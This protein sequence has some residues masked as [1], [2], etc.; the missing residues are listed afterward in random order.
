L[1][2]NVGFEFLPKN[3]I[4]FVY[5]MFDADK[6]GLPDYLSSQDYDDYKDSHLESM[7]ANYDGAT[8]DNRFAWKM[9]YFQS[10]NEDKDFDPVFSDPSGYDDGLITTSEDTQKGAQVQGS[11]NFTDTT[12]TSG[13]DWT[14]YDIDSDYSPQQSE[15]DNL[16]FFVLGK[17]K[18]INQKLI[19][20]GGLRYDDFTV[21][22]IEPA[23]N[24]ES[25]DN[26]SPRV[27]AAYLITDSTKVRVNYGEAF[28][29]P[30]AKELAYDYTAHSTHYVG[31]PDLKPEKS[32][33]YEAGI[34]YS[35]NMLNTTL[36][37]FY[38]DFTDKIETAPG[39]A[40]DEMTW[41]NLGSANLQGIEGTF[42][43]DIGSVFNW[44]HEVKPYASIVYMTRYKDEK[45]NEDLKETSD[46]NASY[47]ISMSDY[48][49]FS[50]KLNF[51]YTGE[52]T[53]TDYES[54]YPYQ[55][56]KTDS[57]TV[58]DLTIRKRLMKV[59]KI[60]EISIKG[61]IR[62]LFDETYYY[63]KGY[64][65]PGRSLYIGLRYDY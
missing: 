65:M 55:D 26:F 61:E 28:S 24:K 12:I 13:V 11:V 6:V 33:T 34:D 30:S 10:E 7:E 39:I 27:G 40:A 43:F 23:G 50:T 14:S 49:G 25:I 38:T 42:S 20:T 2:L 63:A 48:E 56:V 17:T 1:N 46:M 41:K 60:G 8:T 53:V 4:G 29:V 21:E 36:T 31:N 15:Y 62:N 37:Y 51:A 22:I 19:L 57:F 35:K 52:M 32:Q 18:L 59:D 54:G 44:N 45:T 5:N 9:R 47:G 64:P 58:A 16:A 3:R